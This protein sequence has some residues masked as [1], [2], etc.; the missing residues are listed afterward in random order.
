[1]SQERELVDTNRHAHEHFDHLL[2]SGTTEHMAVVAFTVAA[3]ERAVRAGGKEKTSH[4]LRTLA[5]RVDAGQL[6]DPPP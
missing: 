4:W 5:D 6:T 3:I 1:M 2:I